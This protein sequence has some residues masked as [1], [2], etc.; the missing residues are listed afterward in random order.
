MRYVVIAIFLSA[1]TITAVL[2]HRYIWQRL[3]R[4]TYPSGWLRKTLTGL[5]I[6]LGIMTPLAM[7]LGRR[8]PRNT[9]DGF[10]LTAYSWMGL[11]AILVVLLLLVDAIQLVPRFYRRHAEP[12]NTL[13]EVHDEVELTDAEEAE[14]LDELQTIPNPA[15]RQ[16]VARTTGG[17][18][19][20]T[21]VGTFVIGSK[22]ALGEVDVREISVRLP[23][24]PAQLDG[25]K[26]V[27]LTDVHIGPLLDGRFLDAIVDKVNAEKPDVVV[28]TGDLVDGSVRLIGKDVAKLKNLKS[29]YGQFF[30]TGNHEY[31]SGAGD[32][33]RFL[34]TLN[35]Q[36]LMNEHVSI[37]DTIPGGASIDLAGIPDRQG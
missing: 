20:A 9:I 7:A 37:G 34:D 11:F 24:L 23:R 25:L 3:V 22:N 6:A 16:F 18:A 36:T 27:Q 33:T 1:V 5:I 19:A 28:I 29:R 32:W 8:I 2:G 31:Y 26:I 12:N 17:L 13:A 10:F 4:D 15:R 21:A 30:C 35:V 14:L